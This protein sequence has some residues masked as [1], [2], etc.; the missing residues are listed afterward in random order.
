MRRAGT[1][2]PFEIAHYPTRQRYESVPWGGPVGKWIIQ[3]FAVVA[4][5]SNN[6]KHLN[7]NTKLK[8][9]RVIKR[10][11][12]LKKSWLFELF[13]LGIHPEKVRPYP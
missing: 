8:N 1:H 9:R 7:S 3:N 4:K 6:I 2:G 5:Y 13:S 10:N 11:K 12:Q